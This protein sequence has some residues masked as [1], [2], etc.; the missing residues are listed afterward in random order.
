M[1]ETQVLGRVVGMLREVGSAER[2]AEDLPLL[3]AAQT[4]VDETVGGL[5]RTGRRDVG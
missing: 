4:D 3:G 2:L 5:E 1:L